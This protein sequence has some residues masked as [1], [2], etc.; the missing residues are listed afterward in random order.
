MAE[1]SYV[2]RCKCGCGNLVFAMVNNPD[3]KK[4]VAREIS[5]LIRDGYD[6]ETMTV[7][8]VREAPWGCISQ[9]DQP[10]LEG[11]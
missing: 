4:D 8:E 3:H 5:K 10:V 2:A 9:V 6:I 1:E 11:L 7:E